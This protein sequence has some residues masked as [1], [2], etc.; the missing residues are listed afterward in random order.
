MEPPDG[1]PDER[2]ALLLAAILTHQRRRRP[3]AIQPGAGGGGS[4]WRTAGR[5][6]A[7]GAGQLSQRRGWRG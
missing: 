6:R 3:L 2:A 1:H 5:E 4:G 7:L